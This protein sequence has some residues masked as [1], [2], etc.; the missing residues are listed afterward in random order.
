[1]GPNKFTDIFGSD[2]AFCVLE[3]AAISFASH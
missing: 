1:M 3:E 2:S